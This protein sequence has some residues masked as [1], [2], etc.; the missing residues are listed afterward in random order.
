MTI[1]VAI[2]FH[3]P[4]MGKDI[5]IIKMV[6]AEKKRTNKWQVEHLDCVPTTFSYD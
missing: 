6:L 4:N 3:H 1:F 5:N 2:T